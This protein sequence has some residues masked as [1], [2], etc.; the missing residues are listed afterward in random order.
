MILLCHVKHTVHRPIH[1][2]IHILAQMVHHL[3]SDINIMWYIIFCPL[4]SFLLHL[5]K[6]YVC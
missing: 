5:F 2:G 4:W 6:S 3:N 1:Q